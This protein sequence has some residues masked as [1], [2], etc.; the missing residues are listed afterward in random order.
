MCSG[1]CTEGGN[2]GDGYR[3]TEFNMAGS[4][5]TAHR[6]HMQHGSFLF[7]ICSA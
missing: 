6:Q 3:V 5:D 7:H 1:L 4:D 2:A